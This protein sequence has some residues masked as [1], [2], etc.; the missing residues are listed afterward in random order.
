M[1]IAQ[2]LEHHHLTKN[3]FA[4]EDAQ[5]DPVFKNHCITTTFHPAWDKIYGDPYHPATAIVFG[6]KGAGKTALS[7][8][9]RSQ[10][11]KYNQEHPSDRVF[12]LHYD[13]FNPFI[14]HFQAN[15]NP[16]I[17]PEKLLAKWEL[18]DHMDA[19][20]MRGVTRLI[21][22]VL[23]TRP[24]EDT[25]QS[26]Y[27]VREEDVAKLTNY[28]ARDLV[29]LAALYDQSLAE[30]YRGRWK[31]L[32]AKVKFDTTG[33]YIPSTI[34]M[35]WTALCFVVG[36]AL[37][38]TSFY[39][40]I[41]A[42]NVAIVVAGLVALLVLLL[43]W[44]PYLWKLL[45]AQIKAAKATSGI[46]VDAR[47][48]HAMRSILMSFPGDTLTNQPLPVDHMTHSRYALL[49][50]FQDILRTLGFTKMMVLV[51]RVDEPQ[52]INGRPE[53]MRLLVWPL[54]DNKFLKQSSVAVKMLLPSELVGFLER[55]NAEFQQRARLDKQNVVPNF[56]W[57]GEALYDI[58]NARMKACAE[59]GEA[60]NK[61][62]NE[63]FDETVTQE[64]LLSSL[65]SL[66]VPRHM[67]KFL[68]RLLVDHC[69]QYTDSNPVWRITS[70]TYERS[71]GSFMRDLEMQDRGM[72][73]Y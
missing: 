4:D 22:G 23:Q 53:L 26:G 48:L 37:M 49:E 47:E 11:S 65:R 16:R 52:L 42:S 7:L 70:D 20:L 50:K 6:E 66:R 72:A 41:F 28:Q 19:I 63:L 3:P 44:I 46:R 57:T 15:F 24:D 69:S 33:A 45:S 8:Q 29:L 43:G 71:L 55:E 35:F 12:V 17:K 2:F 54:L 18:A 30:T 9:I 21:N 32:A 61:T 64:R 58:A 40:T 51:D 1:R 36:L 67:F 14:G 68:H 59:Q 38:A 13:D 27:R 10:L 60:A 25:Q 34:G 5:S 31:R 62:F 39:E 56:R 73:A